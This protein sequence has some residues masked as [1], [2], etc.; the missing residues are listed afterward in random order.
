M[1]NISFKQFFCT[2]LIS[3]LI[4]ASFF[5]TEA[6]AVREHIKT[7]TI[8]YDT[9]YGFECSVDGLDVRPNLGIGTTVISVG[10]GIAGA[11]ANTNGIDTGEVDLKEE[12]ENASTWWEENMTGDYSL[13]VLNPFCIPDIVDFLALYALIK[14]RAYKI[15]PEGIIATAVAIGT[16]LTL[17]GV[18]YGIASNRS[19]RVELCGYDWTVWGVESMIS[20]EKSSEYSL[21]PGK[22]LDTN[23]RDVFK[24]AG[25]VKG[26]YK[27]SYSK[28]V[29]DCINDVNKCPSDVRAAR[30]E[31]NFSMKD[32]LFREYI[33]QGEE[34]K[35]AGC[36]DPRE[37][38][39]TYDVGGSEQ[40]YYFRG[41]DGTNFAC[42]RF[43]NDKA[44][45]NCCIKASKQ[46]GCIRY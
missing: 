5:G 14:I 42:D 37:E 10:T 25:P 36:I 38:R 16:L 32:K 6:Y 27:G 11:F 28:F 29:Y 45:Y 43:A 21:E 18:R 22:F 41:T 1:N 20:D 23:A 8:K 2:I 13:E 9:R 44:S 40:L 3:I 15:K 4:S 39:E 34:F 12:D 30:K 31:T 24:R 33:Y 7:N 26:M 19:K 35:Y 46:V 17:S